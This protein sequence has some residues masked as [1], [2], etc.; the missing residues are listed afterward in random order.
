MLKES[1]RRMTFPETVPLNFDFSFD[2][3]TLDLR[4]E[5][6]KRMTLAFEDENDPVK[7]LVAR[8]RIKIMKTLDTHGGGALSREEQM[9]LLFKEENDK[10]GLEPVY[11]TGHFRTFNSVECIKNLVL[12]ISLIDEHKYKEAHNPKQKMTVPWATIHS[13]N[14]IIG[15]SSL[16]SMC[17]DCDRK[18]KIG[19]EDVLS[20]TG[21]Q[22]VSSL[23]SM[24][25]DFDRKE[26]VGEDMLSCT[27]GQKLL[28]TGFLKYNVLKNARGPSID[29][30]DRNFVIEYIVWRRIDSPELIVEKY[31]AGLKLPDLEK[32][33][34]PR[35]SNAPATPPT[36]SK[37]SFD[38]C[39][40]TI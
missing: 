32:A 19:G 12:K 39:G 17:G 31:L 21:G 25:G 27:G 26:K 2:E 16:M 4:Y 9:A 5:K 8:K 24:C 35:A 28:T 3:S 40:A 11:V 30:L 7:T 37:H 1:S 10:R 34:Y 13:C 29:S 22:N 23:M 15:V 6:V 14:F 36:T 18:E 38:R 33:Y 20:C